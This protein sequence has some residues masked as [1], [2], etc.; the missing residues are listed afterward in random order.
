M[1]K[2]KLPM[3]VDLDDFCEEIMTPELWGYVLELKKA[4]PE[5]KITMFTIPLKCSE[6]W[7]QWVKKEYSW[8]ELHYH[9]SDH[10]KDRKSVV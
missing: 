4:Q 3:I 8:L 2:T 9:G 1:L 6:K 5:L 10:T 7:L